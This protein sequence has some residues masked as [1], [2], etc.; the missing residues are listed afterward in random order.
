MIKDQLIFSANNPI[1]SNHKVYGQCLLPG[2]AYIDLLYQCFRKH[3]YRSDELEMRNLTIHNPLIVQDGSKVIV[4]VL[5]KE[6]RPGSWKVELEGNKRYA[7]VDMVQMEKYTS[8]DTIDVVL[9]KAGAEATYPIADIYRRYQVR[10]MVHQ[11]FIKAEG[12][13]YQLN[14]G[15]LFD[16][17]LGK[18]AGMTA[19]QFMFHP[20]LMDGSAVAMMRLFDSLVKEDEH[21]FLPLF[22]ESFRAGALINKHCYAFVPASSISRKNDIISFSIYFFDDTGKKVGEL[23]NLTTKK[24]RNGLGD[25]TLNAS[26]PTRQNGAV[27]VSVH[28]FDASGKKIGELNNISAKIFS[29]GIDP[30]D[31]VPKKEGPAAVP[32]TLALGTTTQEAVAFLKE[33]LGNHLRI[34]PASIRTDME[35]YNMGFDSVSLLQLAAIIGDKIGT[36]LPPTL[37]FEYPN[38]SSLANHLTHTYAETFA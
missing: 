23:L 12:N 28:F 20:T 30:T 7:T 14:D 1:T 11:G 33:L 34:D 32:G 8:D 6:T 36:E 16:A 18:E 37:L 21:L 17:S 4:S 25:A 2:L 27:S 13:I 29:E 5:A 26:P 31:E 38:I 3:G 22:Y 35:Y 10:D 15:L 24:V 9:L 19:D